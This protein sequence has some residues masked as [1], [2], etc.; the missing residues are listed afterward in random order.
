MRSVSNR[1]E[2]GVSHAFDT[3]ILPGNH[4]ILERPSSNVHSFCFNSSSRIFEHSLEDRIDCLEMYKNAESR[5]N[6]AG[7]TAS[8]VFQAPVHHLYDLVPVWQALTY[9]RS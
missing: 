5:E 1:L 8:C 7:K 4:G 6:L 9:L 3:C 2:Y